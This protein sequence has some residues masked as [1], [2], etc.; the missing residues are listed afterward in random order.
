VNVSDELSLKL[1]TREVDVS[2]CGNSTVCA[3][4][5]YLDELFDPFHIGE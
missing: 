5:V 2:Q 1:S 4:D 3:V